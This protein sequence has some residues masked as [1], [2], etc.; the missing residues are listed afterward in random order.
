MQLGSHTFSGCLS[1]RLAGE[2]VAPVKFQTFPISKCIMGRHWGTPCNVNSCI[3]ES[4]YQLIAY[5]LRA[6]L[7]RYTFMNTDTSS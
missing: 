7:Y 5:E 2:G 4:T 6:N 3:N 1:G